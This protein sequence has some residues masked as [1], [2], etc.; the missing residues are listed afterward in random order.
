MKRFYVGAMAVWVMGSAALAQETSAP[1]VQAATTGATAAVVATPPSAVTTG[2]SVVAATVTTG[3]TAVAAAASRPV[4][5]AADL[6]SGGR[7]SLQEEKWTEA[8]ALFEKALSLDAGNQEAMFGLSAAYIQLDMLAE[9][10]PLLLTLNRQL[11]LNPMVKNNLAW[12]YLK[13][14]DPAVKNPQKAV[15]FARD[16]VLDVPADY[17]IWNTL[18]EAYYAT[19]QFDRA[20]RAAQSAFRLSALAGV[21]NNAT[22]RELLVRCRK[23]AGV[24]TPDDVGDDQ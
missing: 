18:A 5:E 19:G 11:P 6:L 7:Q 16:A 9:A 20:L 21:T 15:K 2:A 23:A 10:L 14:K 17:S 8:A 13:S 24:G 1:P 3:V 4:G 22:S 12:V